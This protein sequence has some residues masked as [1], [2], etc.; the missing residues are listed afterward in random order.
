MIEAARS[1]S[2]S[3]T[4]AI[5]GAPAAWGL[6]L[7]LSWMVTSSSCAEGATATPIGVG[8]TR[9]LLV[10]FDVAAILV[11]VAALWVGFGAWRRISGD[12]AITAVHGRE[13]SDFLSAIALFIAVVFTMATFLQAIPS[14]SLPVCSTFQ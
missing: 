13:P 12:S 8:A 9:I 1:P 2:R 5:L 6:Q 3:L 11:C 14:F 4:F 10:S 7:F